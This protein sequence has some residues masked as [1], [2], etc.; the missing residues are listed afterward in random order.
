MKPPVRWLV[1]RPQCQEQIQAWQIIACLI[2]IIVILLTILIYIVLIYLAF[3]LKDGDEASDS[4]LIVAWI[5]PA[6]QSALPVIFR[7]S[8]GYGAQVAADINADDPFATRGWF[9]AG[10][11]APSPLLLTGPQNG[12]PYICIETEA[13]RGKK[14]KEDKSAK[15]LDTRRGK[16]YTLH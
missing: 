11:R 8:R 5:Q 7:L 1:Y 3:S 6:T 4:S 9:K 2:C 16:H 14:E 13:N 10:I 12:F 15:G